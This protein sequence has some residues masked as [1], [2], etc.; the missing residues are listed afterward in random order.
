MIQPLVKS[1]FL[2]TKID[3][4]YQF[5]K[6]RLRIVWNYFHALAY[7]EH[8]VFS[9]GENSSIIRSRV[10][11]LTD[12]MIA[13][14]PDYQSKTMHKSKL[15][16]NP[17]YE[18]DS[19]DEE[20]DTWSYKDAPFWMKDKKHYVSISKKSHARHSRRKIPVKTVLL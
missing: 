13:L 5:W 6:D 1:V 17:D 7:D 19:Y 4:P 16:P 9:F 3:P 2:S 18:S 20:Y 15:K 12:I 14:F 11:A 8:V 10:H